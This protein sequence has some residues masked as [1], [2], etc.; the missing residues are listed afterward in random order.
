MGWVHVSCP[1]K[2]WGSH[3]V[4]AW[5]PP[6]PSPGPMGCVNVHVLSPPHHRILQGECRCPSPPKPQCPTGWVHVSCPHPNHRVP[7]TWRAQVLCVTPPKS[8]GPMELGVH[9]SPC[10]KLNGATGWVHMP[11]PPTPPCGGCLYLPPPPHPSRPSSSC[12]GGSDRGPTP[13]PRLPRRGSSEGGSLT[14]GLIVVDTD[15][16]KLQVR[17]PH[18]VAA[19]VDAVFV[20]DHL[21]KLGRTGSSAGREALEHPQTP[22]RG[23]GHQDPPIPRQGWV[24]QEA[25]GYPKH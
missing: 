1:P 2:Q 18:V 24:G 14:R 7:R 21:P 9:D 5:V 19:G 11:A 20:A 16:F 3:G 13:Q 17:V 8:Q 25:L 10:P 6:I 23:T 4:G 15:A 22:G 12:T